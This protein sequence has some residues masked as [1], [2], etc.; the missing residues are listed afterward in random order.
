MFRYPFK[1]YLPSGVSAQN[2]L[3]LS[4]YHIS[5][6]HLCKKLKQS[7]YRPGQAHRVPESR[8]SQISRQSV[9]EGGRLSVI[10]TGRVY[11]PGNIPSTHFC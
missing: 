7:H 8:G 10:R 6:T 5:Q 9:D 2:A 4:A 11:P 3:G 1:F